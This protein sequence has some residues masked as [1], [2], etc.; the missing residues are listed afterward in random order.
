MNITLMGIDPAFTAT[1]L[2][3]ATF[4]GRELQPFHIELIETEKSK[5][6]QVRRN[7]D[8]L[9]RSREIHLSV[10]AAIGR[11]QPRLFFAEVPSGTQSA[12]SSWTLGISVGLLAPISPLV[13]VSAVAV[14][15]H[16][17]GSKTASKQAMIEA[18]V[19]RWPEL[20]W[21]RHGGR[22]TLKN[23]HLADALAVLDYGV[24]TRQFLELVSAASALLGSG[25]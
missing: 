8:D 22:L 2:A 11:H 10:Q 13:E 6:K 14:K 24:T 23:E 5:S 12:R 9:R 15:R 16:F 1:G 19:E 18:A 20:P 25:A 3:L 7:S 4:D 17:V 21:L